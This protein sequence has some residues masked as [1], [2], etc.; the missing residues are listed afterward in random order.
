MASNFY[1]L[2]RNVLNSAHQPANNNTD[3]SHAHAC[4]LCKKVF[5]STQDLLAHIDSHMAQEESAI[6]RLHSSNYVNNS[7]ERKSIASPLFP[8]SIAPPM[9]NQL[10]QGNNF[11]DNNNNK[12]NILFQSPP[13]SQSMVMPTQLRRNSFF[14]GSLQVGSSST[15]TPI[16]QMLLSPHQVVNL[17][18]A[19]NNNNNKNSA[20]SEIG[21]LSISQSN[22][23]RL[24]AAAAEGVSPS[25]GTRSF[26]V[27][28]EKPIKKIDFIDLVSMDDDNSD[29]EPLNLALKL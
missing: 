16:R 28:L 18:Y 13:S 2:R 22:K 8:P 29:E 7:S 5:R 23:R 1:N 3:P 4:R 27:Q 21:Q 20:T 9:P 10:L 17:S 6:R 25:D 15:P 19:G 14:S 12:S 11:A 24:A 26:I